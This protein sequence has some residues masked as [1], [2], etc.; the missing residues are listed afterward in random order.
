[1]ADRAIRHAVVTGASSGI[2]QALVNRLVDEG[3]SVTALGRDTRR[4]ASLSARA[5]T[6]LV[7]TMTADFGKQ[8]EVERAGTTLA[9]DLPELD[10]LVHSAGAY[11]RGTLAEASDADLDLQLAVNLT[12][13]ER[14]TRLLLPALIRAEGQVAF[15]NSSAVLRPQPIAGAYA[16]SKAALRALADS[17]REEVNRHGVR[18]VSIYPGRTDTPLQAAIH[19]AEGRAYDPERLMAADDVAAAV[20]FAVHMPRTAEVTDI[21]LRPM[22]PPA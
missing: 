12:A 16:A 4:L 22:K 9:T 15:I 1:M 18:V 21:M 10:L 8:D 20:L 14:L 17:L 6:G 2:G 11:S 5:G 19:A 7:R 3:T 13:P